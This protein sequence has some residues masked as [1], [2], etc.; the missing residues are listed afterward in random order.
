MGGYDGMVYNHCGKSGLK[1][2]AISLGM[3][4][5]FGTV[6]TFSSMV[7]TITTA[8]DKGITHFD[9]ANNYGSVSGSVEENYGRIFKKE[10][11]SHRDELIFSTKADYRTCDGPYSDGGSR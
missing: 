10:I 8:F 7:E 11:L 3:W 5:N 2:P 1:L 6:D 9:L 4:Y